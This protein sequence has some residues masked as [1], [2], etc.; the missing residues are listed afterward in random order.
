MPWYPQGRAP[1]TRRR[2]SRSACRCP[3]MAGRER[4]CWQPGWPQLAGRKS[5][6]VRAHGYIRSPP[7]SR[8]AISRSSS[9]GSRG[10]DGRRVMSP[11]GDA[12]DAG[13]DDRTTYETLALSVEANPRQIKTRPGRWSSARPTSCSSTPRS[14]ATRRIQRSRSRSSK[15]SL[16]GGHSPAYF[17]QLVQP[18]PIIAAR[19][20]QRSGVVRQVP[21]LLPRARARASVVGPGGRLEELPRAVAQRG[22]RAVLRGAL[23]AASARRRRVR[24]HHAPDA[25]LGDARVRSGPGRTSATGS[26]TS[27]ATAASSA[28]WSTTRAPAVL[29]MLRR[30]VGDEAFF[31]GCAASTRRSRFQ[32]A[33]TDDFRQ[34][35]RSGAGRPLDRF[36]ERWI[37]GS[38]LPRLKVHLPRRRAPSSSVRVE[39]LGEIVRRA[40]HPDAALRGRQERS[41][42]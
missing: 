38:T 35:V 14:S 40:G 9:A 23:R 6:S 3:C 2:R 41:T 33:G 21:G 24:G 27:R 12:V 28:R 29:H 15:A 16:P 17:A 7:I 5:G 10:S 26:A 42:S 36:F 8:C 25:P 37:Y 31:D 19:L 11:R 32:K 13:G 34:R 4:R 1:T 39:Q 30:L 22:L 18:L 20:A